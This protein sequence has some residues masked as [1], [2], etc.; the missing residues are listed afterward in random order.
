VFTGTIPASDSRPTP[1]RAFE[2]PVI[3]LILH[4]S[5][6]VFYDHSRLKVFAGEAGQS[7]YHKGEGRG[8]AEVKAGTWH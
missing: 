2:K 7:I 8:G 1:D 4:L 6:Q 5:Y 3:G